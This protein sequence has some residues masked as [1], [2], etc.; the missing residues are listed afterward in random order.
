M[1]IDHYTFRRKIWTQLNKPPLTLRE[2][3][4]PGVWEQTAKENICT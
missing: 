4:K 2:K 1:K 3:C